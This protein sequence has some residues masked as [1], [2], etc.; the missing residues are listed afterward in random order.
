MGWYLLIVLSEVDLNKES[1]IIVLSPTAANFLPTEN[2][3][4]IRPRDPH[5]IT[6]YWIPIS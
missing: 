1:L 3:S 6:I 2:I 4:L 5:L